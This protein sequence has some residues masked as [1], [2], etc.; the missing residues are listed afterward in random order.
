[1]GADSVA[2]ELARVAPTYAIEARNELC[3]AF[4]VEFFPSIAFV[5]KSKIFT[6]KRGAP[7]TASLLCKAAREVVRMCEEKETDISE[8]RWSA[9]APSQRRATPLRPR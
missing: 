5:H 6:W 1:M 8:G 9:R 3:D 7:R 2:S 4:R